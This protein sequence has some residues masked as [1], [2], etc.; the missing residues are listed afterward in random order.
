[1]QLTETADQ[2]IPELARY[3]RQFLLAGGVGAV[4]SLVGYFTNPVVLRANLS[5]R[6]SFIAVLGQIGQRVV[7]ALDHQDYPFA[8]LVERVLPTRY[9]A[10][11]PI[12][13]VMLLFQKPHLVEQAAAWAAARGSTT[14]VTPRS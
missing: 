9:P 4:L 10:R 5:G 14:K 11:S 8:L 3:Q 6:P 1:M 13:Q 2:Q 12:F 7:E